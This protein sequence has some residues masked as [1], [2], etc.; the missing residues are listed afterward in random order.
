LE[1]DTTTPLVE[2]VLGSFFPLDLPSVA[3]EGAGTYLMKRWNIYIMEGKNC[4]KE[5]RKE[6]RTVR[7]RD[8]I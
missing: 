3:A 4:I 8:T 6:R 1:Y 7:R 2:V 5:G